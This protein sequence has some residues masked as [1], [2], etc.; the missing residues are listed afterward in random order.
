MSVAEAW[1]YSTV[2][3]ATSLY[4][5]FKGFVLLHFLLLLLLRIGRKAWTERA[6]SA[7]VVT[8]LGE[9]QRHSVAN[10]LAS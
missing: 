4:F 9:L 2:I 1:Q 10:S 7:V 5:E 8:R 6:F 3:I